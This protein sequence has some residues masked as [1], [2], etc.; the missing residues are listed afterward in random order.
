LLVGREYLYINLARIIDS[1]YNEHKNCMLVAGGTYAEELGN[2]RAVTE[3]PFLVPGIGKQGGDLEASITNSMDKNGEG[4]LINS[5]SGIWFA[6]IPR[7]AAFS[8]HGE[9]TGIREKVLELRS[10]SVH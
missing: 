4:F 2:I 8:L 9:I 6:K 1:E 5:S 3:M 7:E 10:S